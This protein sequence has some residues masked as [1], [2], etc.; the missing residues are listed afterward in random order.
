MEWLEEFDVYMR[1]VVRGL[2]HCRFKGESTTTKTERNIPDQTAEEKEL[3]NY[4]MQFAGGA[5]D[6]AKYFLGDNALGKAAGNVY[7]ADWGDL[8]DTAT[9]NSKRDL[10]TYSDLYY[11]DLS[12]YKQAMADALVDY[13]DAEDKYLSQYE[14][15]MADAIS[16]Y[17]SVVDK[18]S[19]LWDNLVNGILPEAYA[20]NRQAA[21]RDDVNALYGSTINNAASRGVINSSV[22]NKA[23]SDAEQNLSD[24]L[25]KM[26]LEDLSME[27]SLLDQQQG[28]A[29]NRYNTNAGH[30]GSVYGNQAGSAR[31]K[32]AAQQSGYN[33]MVDRSASAY[34]DWY[35]NKDKYN[36]SLLSNAATAQTG[37]Y[38][39]LSNYINYA[40]TL[41]QPASNLFNT[42]YSGRMGTGSTTTTQSSGNNGAWSVVGAL[43]AGIVCFTGDTLIATPEG[44]KCI[45][46]IR[47]GD[48]VL[49]WKDGTVVEKQVSLVMEPREADIVE[50]YFDNGTV[51]H[52]TE[53]QRYFDGRHFNYVM[54]SGKP[55]VVL[56]GAPAE[57]IRVV[58]PGRREK[59]YDFTV[60]GFAGENVYFANDVAAEG[61]GD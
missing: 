9:S 11:S 2:G 55:A 60:H 4:L 31:A 1:P 30:A 25:A 36:S 40:S 43:G 20:T 14:S 47:E 8:Y 21:L 24:T 49:S 3:Q 59:V 51:W 33:D 45:R 57:I 26:Y 15:A 38:E 53:S 58:R 35:G 12:N 6:I 42:M 18:Q 46:D 54:H 61:L 48:L 52:T 7:N 22:T 56:N 5:G 16:K 27:A 32:I 17:N 10:E 23:L 50:V 34:N 28:Y 29:Q 37:S 13:Q 41:Y 19:P 39:P 44:Y